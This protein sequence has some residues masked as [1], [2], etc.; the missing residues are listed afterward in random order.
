MAEHP[1]GDD[2][3][4]APSERRQ[5]RRHSVLK[6]GQLIF[7]F[8]GSTIDCLILDESEAGVQAET[9]VMIEFPERLQLR[10][11]GGAIRDVTRLWA[12]GTRAGLGFLEARGDEALRQCRK[13]AAVALR[14]QGL[15]AAMRLL[16]EQGF[17]GSAELQ[18]AAEAAE[19]ALAR[20]NTLLE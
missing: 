8:G 18:Q 6:R 17:C 13:A 20:L 5:A 7:G 4:T 12:V 9:A 10:Y 3:G 19:L 16:R 1:P 2:D 15:P 11:G 14:S